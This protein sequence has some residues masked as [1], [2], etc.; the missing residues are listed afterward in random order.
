MNRDHPYSP[1]KSG[2]IFRR[3]PTVARVIGLSLLVFSLLPF[4]GAIFLLNQ[5]LQI[6][7]LEWELVGIGGPGS[8]GPDISTRSLLVI[9]ACATGMAWVKWSTDFRRGRLCSK[10]A[11][12]SVAVCERVPVSMAI[13]TIPTTFST[14]FR[15]CECQP[16]GRRNDSLV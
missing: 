11:A 1:P 6:V 4:A 16:F 7:P 9:L 2:R 8:D 13:R 12:K 15:T 10:S 5:E 14:A 3:S